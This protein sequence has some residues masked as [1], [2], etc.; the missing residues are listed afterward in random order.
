MSMQW[1]PN[2]VPYFYPVQILQFGME[3]FVKNWTNGKLVKRANLAYRVEASSSIADY[4]ATFDILQNDQS[5]LFHLT[6]NMQARNQEKVLREGPLFYT[7]EF[8]GGGGALPFPES[9]CLPPAKNL[10]TRKNFF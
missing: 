8:L 4:S 5:G 10:S 2:G 6:K 1:E 9:E 3:H 7:R